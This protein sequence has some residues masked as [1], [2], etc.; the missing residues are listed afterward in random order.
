M[1]LPLSRD[2]DAADTGPLPAPTVN[3]LQDG[4]VGKKHGQIVRAYDMVGD[5]RHAG[6]TVHASFQYYLCVALSGRVW[7][8][9]YPLAPGDRL[10][11]AAY[12]CKDIA[13]GANGDGL[14]FQINYVGHIPTVGWTGG[15]TDTGYSAKSGSAQKV[16]IT[17][18][19]PQVVAAG[20]CIECIIAPDPAGDLAGGNIELYPLFEL[21]FDHQ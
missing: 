18:A 3:N 9:V 6:W 15:V 7:R 1:P 13:P 4:L 19:T 12:Y 8:H 5:R 14:Q 16:T 17:L 11:S 20:Y 10:V 2:Y 21:A